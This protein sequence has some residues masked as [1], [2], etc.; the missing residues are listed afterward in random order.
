[1][2][3]IILL[4][5]L[6]L[7]L[8]TASVSAQSKSTSS[9]DIQAAG[10]SVD[11]TLPYPGLLPDN[12]LYSLK[13]ARDNII[14]FLISDTAKKAEFDLLQA[15]KRLQGGYYLFNKDKSKAE[16]I[17]TTISKDENYFEEAISKAIEIQKL[18]Q[19]ATVFVGKL[20]LS[21]AKHKEII[22]AM[23]SKSKGEFKDKLTS[24]EKRVDSFGAKIK[25]L[26]P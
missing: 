12:P 15:D 21:N 2:K 10:S 4:L 6:L 20:A 7:L 14:G 3:K 16:L 24:L 25:K 18:G 8:D 19:N 26:K 23:E 13:T 1:M 5:S 9:A 22:K 17:E 11:Y